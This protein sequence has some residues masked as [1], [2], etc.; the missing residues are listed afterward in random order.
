MTQSRALQSENSI[1]KEDKLIINLVIKLYFYNLY[2]HLIIS[3][4]L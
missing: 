3:Q 2:K 1:S 4:R